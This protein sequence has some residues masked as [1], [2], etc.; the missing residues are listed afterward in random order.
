MKRKLKVYSVSYASGM[1][2]KGGYSETDIYSTKK[3]KIGDFVVVEHIG[4]GIFI[5]QVVDST[6]EDDS[7]VSDKEIRE[8][9]EY[10][11]I[12]DIDLTDYMAEI[13]K[14]ERKEELK[15]EME[16]MFRAIDKEQKFEYYST[17]DNDFKKLYDEYKNL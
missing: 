15:S 10:R 5:G 3:L 2:R 14:A 13:K 6:F 11:Y 16:E 4:Y 12:Q 1:F 7:R 8:R 17:I 9:I